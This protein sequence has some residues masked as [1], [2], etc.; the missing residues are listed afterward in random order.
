M[1]PPGGCWLGPC[2]HLGHAVGG[3]VPGLTPTFPLSCCLPADLSSAKRKF[4][5]SLN[6]FKFN[7]IGDA[8]TDDE[9]CIGEGGHRCVGSLGL[10][11]TP[12]AGQCRG[13][14]HSGTPREPGLQLGHPLLGPAG[15]GQPRPWWLQPLHG[16]ARAAEGG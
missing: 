5:D 13:W 3:L 1:G 6:E 15:E 14:E 10:L 2:A 12:R 8:E 7:C 16:R 9:I 4:A 11:Q